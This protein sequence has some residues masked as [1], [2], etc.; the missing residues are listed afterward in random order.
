MDAPYENVRHFSFVLLFNRHDFLWMFSS[1]APFLK[2]A[3]T[4]GNIIQRNIYKCIPYICEF[5]CYQILLPPTLALKEIKTWVRW[6]MSSSM[7]SQ[8]Q[9]LN[10]VVN[11]CPALMDSYN[12]VRLSLV[13]Q[14]LLNWGKIVNKQQADLYDL[15]LTRLTVKAHKISMDT[16]H[17]ASP[18]WSEV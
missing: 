9:A 13:C 6:T 4:W 18:F 5:T 17:P 16:S 12:S 7:W 15:Y 2:R 8:S 11:M 14:R 3:W 1:M 10:P